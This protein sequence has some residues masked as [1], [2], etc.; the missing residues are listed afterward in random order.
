MNPFLDK[1][2]GPVIPLPTPFKADHSVDLDA[3]RSYVNWLIEHGIRNVMTTVGTS[4]YNLLTADEVKQVNEAVVSAADGRAITIVANP[5]VG[6]TAQAVDFAQHAES[7]GAD[8]YLCIYPDRNYGEDYIFDFFNTVAQ[9][10]K[11]GILLHEMPMR[12]GLGG[13]T[14]QYSL[15]LLDRLFKVEN[16]VGL[17]EES[18]DIGYGNKVVKAISEKAVVIGAG[19]G[20]SRYLR[21]YWLGA[22]AFLGGIGNFFPQLELEFFEAMTSRDYDKAFNI[23]HDIEAPFFSEM[24]SIGWHPGLKGALAAKGLIPVHERAPLKEIGEADMNTIKNLLSNN[25][26]L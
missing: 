6:G 3:M 2:T 16:I 20:M 17:K 19:G 9:S 21:D 15:P 4:R 23:V 7:I 5:P 13:G 24:I 18:L 14:V 22:Q 25:G 26:W 1:V 11:T 8:L 10:V 12:N